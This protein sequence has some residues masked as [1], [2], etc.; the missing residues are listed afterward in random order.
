MADDFA[1][2]SRLMFRPMRAVDLDRVLENETRSYAFPW[3]RGVFSDCLKAR[4]ECWVA[5]CDELLVGHGVLSVAASEAHL[6]NVCVRRDQQGQGLGRQI[7]V[8]MLERARACGART[9]YLE[10]RPSNRVASALY[11]S[12][13]F[14]EIGRRKEYYPA[15]MGSEDAVVL[16]LT[17]GK[18]EQPTAM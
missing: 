6:L 2:R 16:A 5:E 15:E 1:P 3:T 7:V 14:R 12:L 17:L 9:V 8:H 18:A 13:G 4:H 11:L 10:V